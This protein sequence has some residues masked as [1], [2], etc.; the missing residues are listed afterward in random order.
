VTAHQELL[1]A[2]VQNPE[3]D[4]AR[5]AF[6]EEIRASEPDRALFVELQIEQARERR[7]VHVRAST[8]KDPLLVRHDDEW[9][10]TLAKYV[11]Y[12]RYDRGFVTRVTIDPHLFL[13]YGEWLMSN[14]PIRHV[15]F[16]RPED[17]DLPIAALAESPLL[18]TLEGIHFMSDVTLDDGSLIALAE[19]G[20]LE[21]L[22]DF[23]LHDR[24]P[25]GPAVYE[26]FAAS[27]QTR[28][29]LQFLAGPALEQKHGYLPWLHAKNACEP[30]DARYYV[31]HGILP[32]KSPGSR[33]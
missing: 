31:D 14:A 29:L 25:L 7:P 3:D 22:L 33:A 27:A 2:I 9:T 21:R 6:A 20:H 10:R 1:R 5:L 15:W 13:E 24:R 12:W 11:T 26:A 32:V 28:K 4:A 18:E 19:G 23:G 16:S 17:D 8:N 30:F